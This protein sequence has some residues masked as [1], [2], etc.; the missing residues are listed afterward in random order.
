MKKTSQLFTLGAAL[1]LVPLTPTF[2][3]STWQTVDDYQTVPGQGAAVAG[4]AAV[5]NGVVFSACMVDDAT[6]Q[7]H[8][9]IRRSLDGGQSWLNVFDVPNT[10]FAN[11]YGVTVG[12]SGLGTR[13]IIT[14]Q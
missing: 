11:C 5:D 1:L 7:R 10:T 6:G 12:P 3:Q 9:V 8:G 2:A 4:I 14:R 13:P